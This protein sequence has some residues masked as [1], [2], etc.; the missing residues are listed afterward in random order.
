MRD[1]LKSSRQTIPPPLPRSP[2][3]RWRSPPHAI[4]VNQ[5]AHNAYVCRRANST[6]PPCV[7]LFGQ[8]LANKKKL[9]TRACPGELTNNTDARKRTQPTPPQT[10]FPK[11][12]FN[13]RNTVSRRPVRE[14]QQK[15]GSKHREM[16]S[17]QQQKYF[18]Q[19]IYGDSENQHSL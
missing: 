17:H 12:N 3:V 4:A 16:A 5:Y 10:V 2:R 14:K 8:T 7:T 15:G 11:S 19:I 6:R 18:T 9:P 1:R 13:F